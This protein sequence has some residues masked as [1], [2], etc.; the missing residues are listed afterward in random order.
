MADFFSEV[1]GVIAGAFQRLRHEDDL[2][3]QLLA[4]DVLGSRY[5]A[6]HEVAHANASQRRRGARRWPWGHRVRRKGGA[7]IVGVFEEGRHLGE[8]AEHL[9][10]RRVR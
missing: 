4:V 8:I 1:L 3:A 6:G 5:G 2:Q 10:S 7:G 9:R